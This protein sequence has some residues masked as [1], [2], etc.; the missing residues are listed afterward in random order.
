MNHKALFI[1][2]EKSP[3]RVS[4]NPHAKK[5]MCSRERQS[6]REELKIWILSANLSGFDPSSATYSVTLTELVSFRM[7]QFPY[8]CKMQTLATTS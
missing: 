4:I 1:D 6:R 3:W 8:V 5:E 2:I 7:P